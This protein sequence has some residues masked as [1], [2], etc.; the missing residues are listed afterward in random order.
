MDFNHPFQ[1]AGQD[2]GGLEELEYLLLAQDDI[3]ARTNTTYATG[4]T[5]LKESEDESEHHGDHEAKE[6]IHTQAA[7]PS[8]KA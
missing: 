8:H 2:T 1:T 4:S 3:S 6:E 5:I 7:V